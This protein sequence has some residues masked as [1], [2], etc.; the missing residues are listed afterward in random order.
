MSALNQA[1]NGLF[2]AIPRL[3]YTL[4]ELDIGYNRVEGMAI[5]HQRMGL[6]NPSTRI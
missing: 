4:F 1:N 5:S 3:F 6:A 2:T